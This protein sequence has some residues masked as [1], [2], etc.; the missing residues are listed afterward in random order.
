MIR[1]L[2]LTLSLL[3]IGTLTAFAANDALLIP[4]GAK[5]YIAPQD[6]FE[7]Y[8]SAALLKKAVPVSIVANRA[9]AD[10]EITGNAK[11]DNSCWVCPGP[12]CHQ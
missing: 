6:G 8:L 7:N 1:R 2:I 12:L 9:M 11:T 4:K 10:F 5:V 3:S